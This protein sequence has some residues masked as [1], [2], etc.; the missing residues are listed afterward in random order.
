MESIN[1]PDSLTSINSSVFNG[2]RSL[3]SVDIPNKV[4][5][6][7]GRAFCDCSNLTSI[8]IPNSVI[9][10]GEKAF[11]GCYNLPSI[12]IPNSVVLIDDK[13]FYNCNNL[14]KVSIGHGLQKARSDV[15]ERCDRICSVNINNN[16]S[17]R[18][19]DGIKSLKEVVFEDSVTIIGSS[20]FW[21]CDSLT[22]V[23]IGK[24]VKTINNNAFSWAK[25]IIWLTEEPPVGYAKTRGE[26]N[27]VMNDK[28]SELKNQHIYPLLNSSFKVDGIE[29]VPSDDNPDAS[30]D[31]IGYSFL[32]PTQIINIPNIVKGNHKNY[33]VCRILPYAFHANNNVTSVTIN[34]GINYIGTY[35]FGDCNNLSQIKIETEN[36]N[37]DSRDNCNAIVETRTNKL[38]QGCKSTVIPTSIESIG[39]SA[40]YRLSSLNNLI[41]P[42][43]IKSIGKYAFYRCNKLNSITLSEGLL[44][45]GDNAFSDCNSLKSLTIPASIEKIGNRAFISCGMSTLTILP[46][47]SISVG[48]LA[49]GYCSNL[50]DIKTNSIGRGDPF[51]GCNEVNTI[52]LNMNKLQSLGNYLADYRKLNKIIIGDNVSYIDIYYVNYENRLTSI[53]VDKNNKY[54]DSRDSCNAIINT[55]SNNLIIGCQS[56]IIPN[57]INKIGEYAFYRCKDLNSINIP[58]GVISIGPEAFYECSNLATVTISGSV[59]KID[60]RAF[61]YCTNLASVTLPNSLT[62]IGGGAFYSCRSLSSV[63]IPNSVTNIGGSAFYGCTSLSNIIIPTSVI[64]IGENAFNSTL[65]YDNLKDGIIYINNVLYGYKGTM[66]NNTK[67]DITE[68]TISI[69]GCAFLGCEGMVSVNIPNSIK[70]IGSSAFEGCTGL[71]SISIPNS[72]KKN[73]YNIFDGCSNITN[74]FIDIDTLNHKTAGLIPPTTKQLK[75]GDNV[76][77]IT[78]SENF[79]AKEIEHLDIG[80]GVKSIY[81]K[82]F[83][84]CFKLTSVSL[85]KNI[86]SIG[87]FAFSYCP[88]ENLKIDTKNVS[89]WFKGFTSLKNVE[90]GDNVESI[91]NMAFSGCSNITNIVL[92]NNISSI[93][94]MA[95]ANCSGLTSLHLPKNLKSFKSNAFEGCY[96]LCSLSIDSYNIGDSWF[97]DWHS[98]KKVEFGNSVCSIGAESFSNCTSLND[99]I[100]PNNIKTIGNV[101]FWGCTGATNIYIGDSVKAIGYK[102]FNHCKEA[103]KLTLGKEL[104]TIGENAFSGC[105][106]LEQIISKSEFPP[107][108]DDDVFGGVDKNLCKLQ[109][110]DGCVP[111]YKKAEQWKEFFG[112]YD[113]GI[114][115]AYIPNSISY[116]YDLNGYKLEKLQKGYNIIRKNNGQ[117]KKVF[118]K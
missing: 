47:E 50:T 43:N 83:Y 74:C 48:T 14:V 21:S 24:N 112:I 44:S 36:T 113:T 61:F 57:N 17:D 5:N 60:S 40:F 42:N 3:T 109:V 2:C 114:K 82:S 30:C 116:I 1:I 81:R 88:I 91:G 15:F 94:T 16:N 115:D 98:L 89:S 29:Y 33:N 22:S 90:F 52:Y 38:I 64:D 23:V 102:A 10:I 99:I 56:S 41:I 18:L 110:P 108:C 6:I 80:N 78:F 37:Y 67:M 51:I 35:A 13:A 58:D 66:P 34:S 106:S 8:K 85:G 117:I 73:G 25:K 46:T 28:Y 32:S 20:A 27:Y 9:N 68:G 101:A 63:T 96:N 100:I 55:E 72:V 107:I 11:S 70:S 53:I 97:E 54:F 31:V 59:T 71:T 104:K 95:F 92:G 49:F 86:N 75:L 77:N 45:I 87:E 103:K 118:I 62:S 7:S 79:P 19:F 76:S 26:I 111:D 12:T 84:R 105:T 65:W 39:D 93:G 4:T 69:S